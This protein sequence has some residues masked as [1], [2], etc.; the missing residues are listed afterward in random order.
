MRRR[1][2]WEHGLPEPE[3][4]KEFECPIMKGTMKDPVVAADGST[5]E[6]D[7]IAHW[8]RVGNTSPITNEALQNKDLIPNTALK[9]LIRD[10]PAK[11]HK[12]LMMLKRKVESPADQQKARDLMAPTASQDTSK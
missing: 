1:E 12:R 11:E 6:R 8:L 2:R 5:Y 4:P 9:I 10:W 7:D 3:M